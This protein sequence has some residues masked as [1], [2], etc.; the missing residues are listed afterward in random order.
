MIGKLSQELAHVELAGEPKWSEGGLVSGV[1]HL[2][3]SY[4]WRT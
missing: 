1:K 4:E 3:I 2:P